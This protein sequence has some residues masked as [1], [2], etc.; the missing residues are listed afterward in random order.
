[1]NFARL[2]IGMQRHIKL[3]CCVILP[4]SCGTRKPWEV[5]DRRHTPLEIPVHLDQ[6]THGNLVC[7]QQGP[8]AHP[9]FAVNAHADLHLTRRNIE[10]RPAC[11]RQGAG[12]KR[13]AERIGAIVGV[14]RDPN[15]L[16]EE[17]FRLLRR[18]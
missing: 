6:F 5:G 10:V 11:L 8:A 13:D 3:L 4:F 14:T 18:D 9:R 7:G 2:N 1:M 17:L 16:I 12:R 15:D